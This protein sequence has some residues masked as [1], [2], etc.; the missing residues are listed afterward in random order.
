MMR[1]TTMRS[2][3]HR[4]LWAVVTAGVAACGDP[5]VT[6]QDR[7]DVVF[8]V[9][10]DVQSGGSA[11]NGEYTVGVLFLHALVDASGP[12]LTNRIQTELVGS[13]ISGQFPTRFH[14]E[15]DKAPAAYRFNLGSSYSGY[16]LFRVG[17]T[18]EFV[19][20]GQLVIGPTRE[21]AALPAQI[22][23]EID[24]DHPRLPSRHVGRALAPYLPNTTIT[25]YQ[26]VYA[27]GVEP[28]DRMYPPPWYTDVTGGLEISE[29]FTLADVGTYLDSLTWQ[30]CREKAYDD[31]FDTEEYFY[32]GRANAGRIGCEDAC[33]R[34]FPSSDRPEHAA[35]MA[36]CVTA[37]S[38]PGERR[39][40]PIAGRSAAG[41]CQLRSRAHT[42]RRSGADLERARSAV[43]RARQGRYQTEAVATA[44]LS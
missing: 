44:Y 3:S 13:T 10:G 7:G 37:F 9:H 20:V 36:S 40:L 15:L 25:K 17:D 21:L 43:V 41:R 1:K 42:E 26:V 16:G 11:P 35:C 38:R 6:A 34:A 29:G 2:M 8:G 30:D 33:G 4:P 28:E 32:C 12:V 31:A 19:R 23:F 22:D 39:R 14:V 18:P 24:V 27:E 5:L